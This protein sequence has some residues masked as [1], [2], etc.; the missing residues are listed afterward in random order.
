M[1]TVSNAIQIFGGSL[2]LDFCWSYDLWIRWEYVETHRT[3]LQYNGEPFSYFSHAG[4]GD[5][6]SLKIYGPYITY[7]LA[8]FSFSSWSNVCT[9]SAVYCVL[10]GISLCYSFRFFGHV[11][12]YLGWCLYE[13]KAFIHFRWFIH[14]FSLSGFHCAPVVWIFGRES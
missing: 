3:A 6:Y 9:D 11:C 10:R 5:S 7:A 1:H 13:A 4:A 8:C 12:I 14:A 2:G